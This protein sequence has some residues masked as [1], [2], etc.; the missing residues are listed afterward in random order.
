MELNLQNFFG[1]D[2]GSR[3]W[4]ESKLTT[5]IK[6]ITGVKTDDSN[7]EMT[8]VKTDDSNK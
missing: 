2:K 5:V 1:L 3:G 7:K 4:Q 8:G 6:R